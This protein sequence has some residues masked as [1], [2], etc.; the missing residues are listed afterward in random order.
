[1]VGVTG[2]ELNLK[3]R[4]DISP[5]KTGFFQCFS[6]NNITPITYYQTNNVPLVVP[7]P[8][9]KEPGVYYALKGE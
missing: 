2:L 4:R 7:S 1:M 6:T 5:V 3:V 8:P 9:R